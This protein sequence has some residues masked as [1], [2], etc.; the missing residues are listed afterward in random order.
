MSKCVT[1]GPY[2]RLIQAGV[3]GQAGVELWIHGHAFR[4]LFN[5]DFNAGKDLCAWFSTAR[6]LAVRCSFG[7]I[8]FD[9]VVMYAPQRGRPQQEINTWWQEIAELLRTRK[10][11]IPLFVLGDFNCLV[12]SVTDDSIGPHAGDIEDEAG[13]MLRNVCNEMELMMPA[14]FSHFHDGPTGT[15]TAVN[16]ASSRI[17]FIL[18]PQQCQHDVVRSSVDH[19]IDVM[20]GDRDHKPLVLEVE[21]RWKP[22]MESGFCRSQFYDK[23]TARRMIQNDGPCILAGVPPQ[24]WNMDV[25]EHWAI[26][27]T[28]HAARGWTEIPK[29][30]EKTKTTLLSTTNL[31]T[32][33]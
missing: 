5:C 8:N 14:T 23:D 10:Q 29:A 12:G 18:I 26:F 6:V 28:A 24:A 11:D 30:K 21:L 22:N 9:L 1:T 31:A 15:F 2:V 7:M 32:P 25:N 19:E 3:N 17:D 20:I 16:G 27:A 13:A 33:L 4:S